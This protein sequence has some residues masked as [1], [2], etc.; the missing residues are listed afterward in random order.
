VVTSFW[1]TLGDVVRGEGRNIRFVRIETVFRVCLG[2]SR[3][4]AETDLLLSLG[5]EFLEASDDEFN[6]FSVFHITPGRAS[7]LPD[8][9]ISMLLGCRLYLSSKFSKPIQ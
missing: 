6:E 9:F 2:R 8:S 3:V 7:G 1:C 4:D 5:V